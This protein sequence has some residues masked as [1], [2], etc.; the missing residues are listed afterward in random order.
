MFKIHNFHGTER[1]FLIPP[2]GYLGRKTAHSIEAQLM[3]MEF[4]EYFSYLKKQYPS[5]RLRRYST[6]LTYS[7]NKKDAT[8]IANN[9][10]K[11]FR[12]VK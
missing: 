5:I 9:L 7:A 10:N 4:V 1:Y 12:K 11:R 8:K 6:F 3:G 2:F